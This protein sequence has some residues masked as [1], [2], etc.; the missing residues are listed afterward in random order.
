VTGGGSQITEFRSGHI[1]HGQF[2]NATIPIQDGQ[3][4]VPNRSLINDRGTCPDVSERVPLT[5]FVRAL[6]M[7]LNVLGDGYVEAIDD[8]TLQGI[9]AQQPALSRGRVAG[10]VIQVPVLE[11]PGKTRVGRFGWKNQHASLLSFSSDA[12][13][14]EQ[15]ITNRLNMTDTTQVCK[16]TSD[17]EDHTDEN[18]MDDIDHFATFI[19]GTMSPPVDA[20]LM[21]TS[22]AQSG[23]SLFNSIG[24]SVCHV[25]SITTAAPGTKING[26]AFVVPD[27]L[28]SKTIHPY[29]D[30]L[31]HNIGTGDGIVQ[32]GPTDTALKMRT[33]PLWGLRTHD[34]LMHDG[35]SASREEAIIRHGG[36]A[37]STR[38][39]FL[40]LSNKQRAQLLTF[41]DAL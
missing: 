31:L 2:V 33:A 24:C 36:E 23:S 10:E 4:S 38:D 26:D 32:N 9:A 34:R 19:R 8:S 1:S 3:S 17:P 11:A 29:S 12:Y 14:N 25:T 16:T 27:A 15:G 7:S 6:R 22:D 28:G 41:L 35:L 39:A 30:F 37:S 5:E 40:R 13:L 21:A 18:G 20:V